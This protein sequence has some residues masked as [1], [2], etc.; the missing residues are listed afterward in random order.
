M[1]NLIIDGMEERCVEG[2]TYLELA[3]RYQKNYEHAILLAENN[4]YLKELNKTVECEGEITFLTA[5]SAAG[6]N[7][8]HRSVLFLFLK[9][10]YQTAG[11]E[12]VKNVRVHFSVL[13]GLLLEIDAAVPVNQELL[14][15]IKLQMREIVEQNL[16]IVKRNMPTREAIQIFASHGMYDKE[17]LF[18]FRRSSTVNVYRLEDF[19]DY[20]YGYMVPDSGYL[21]YFDLCMYEDYVILQ[22]PDQ[23]AP[24]K[25][26]DFIPQP[27]LYSAL[28]H[29]VSW[30]KMLGVNTVGD[31][32]AIVASGKITELILVQEALQE[33][34]LAAIAEEI[35]KRPEVKFI[36]IAGPSSS[37]KTTT[38]RRLGIQLKAHGLRPHPISVDNYFVEREKSPR[39]AKGEYNFECLEALDLELFNQDMCA[40][41]EGKE[42]ELP[43]YNFVSGKREYKGEKLKMGREDVLVIEGIHA[44][45]DAMSYKLP[46]ESKFRI[47]LSAL[48]QLN[49]DEHN[50]IP[51]TDGR[52][53]RRMVRDAR[54]RGTSAQETIRRWASV[55][56]GEESNIFPFQEDAD[57]IFDS[58]LIYELAVLKA[59]AEPLLFQIPP[60]SPEGAEARRL[61]KF[62]DY[63]LSVGSENIPINSILREFVGGSCFDV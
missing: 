56:A 57:V 40:L 6:M 27:K 50:R 61:L 46:K 19:E 63:F 3:K 54:T 33:K 32:N 43:T 8:Y 55:R 10:L 14:E 38:S 7:T 39:D 44:L 31:L 25:I 59:Y 26:P 28:L 17:R 49:I 41:L 60:Q 48:T 22:L 13:K 29:S 20:F 36:M 34:R 35:S 45:N 62:F 23:S 52:L 4:G 16:P 12:N 18:S 30:R 37:G 9:S 2:T 42:I 11:H 51:T 53:I 5:E 15:K 24:E 47:Y 58:S 21:K 1:L